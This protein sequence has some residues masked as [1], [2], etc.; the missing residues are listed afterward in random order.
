LEAGA[1]RLDAFGRRLERAFLIQVGAVLEARDA[2]AK[3]FRIYSRRGSRSTRLRRF[4]R[5]GETALRRSNRRVQ[6]EIKD[7]RRDID[8]QTAEWR[9]SAGSVIERLNPVA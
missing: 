5:R 6:R 9:D 1:L 3:T 7:V 8:R 2:A 4:E